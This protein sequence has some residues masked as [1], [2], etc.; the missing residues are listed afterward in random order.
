MFQGEEQ[1]L[2]SQI[3]S[4][5]RTKTLQHN[6]INHIMVHDFLAICTENYHEHRFTL[7]E[8]SSI[9]STVDVDDMSFAL[10]RMSDLVCVG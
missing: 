2:E 8:V 10:D 9:P 3:R 1:P 4:Q 7:C 5:I 6:K